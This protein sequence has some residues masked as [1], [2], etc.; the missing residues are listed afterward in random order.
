MII[1]NR[2]RYTHLEVAYAIAPATNRVPLR[3]QPHFVRRFPSVNTW[4]RQHGADA[5]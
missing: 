3:C 5:P 4:S 2:V 1:G